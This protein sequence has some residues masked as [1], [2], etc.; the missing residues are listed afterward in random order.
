MPDKTPLPESD[1]E[2]DTSSSTSASEDAASSSSD[3]S[4]GTIRKE[5]NVIKRKVEKLEKKKAAAIAAIAADTQT[6]AATVEPPAIDTSAKARTQLI[7]E[8]SPPA[9]AQV[10]D[11]E[12]DEHPD[13][14][15]QGLSMRKILSMSRD[16]AIGYLIG[17]AQ[18]S[19]TN[20]AYKKPSA[21]SDF[22]NRI[23]RLREALRDVPKLNVKNWYAWQPRLSSIISTWPPATKHLLGL[24]KE[25]DKKYDRVLDGELVTVI[26]GACLMN[27]TDNIAYLVNRPAYAEPWRIHEFY[28][29]LKTDLT[30]MDQLNK[31]S[32]LNQVGMIR[33]YHSD[34]RKLVHDINSHWSTALSMGHDL[35]EV[36]KIKTLLDQARYNPTYA[37]CIDTLEDTGHS[38]D[39]NTVCAA[40]FKRQ[41]R[42]EL[43]QAH[44][45][46]SAR[47]AEAE[48][49]PAGD[50]SSPNYWRGRPG[51]NG[52]PAVCYNCFQPGHISRVCTAPRRPPRDDNANANAGPA[53]APNRSSN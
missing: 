1:S 25:G 14:V 31:A 49:A 39:F 23:T 30:K 32:L 53:P 34:V 41:D 52:G 19:E 15:A 29:H 26:Q 17:R 42:L 10:Y 48:T 37:S 51:R 8:P 6:T 18:M 21:R 45:V 36:T 2:A 24:I 22:H 4:A 33:M 16:E 43:K 12:D 50:G 13:Q 40:L 44:R 11:E 5:V 9:T 38:S 46:G 28:E 27:G 7:L 3:D 35:G 20:D 47:V